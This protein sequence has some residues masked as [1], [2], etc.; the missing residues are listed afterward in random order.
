METGTNNVPIESQIFR[1]DNLSLAI[2]LSA[3]GCKF[4]QSDGRTLAGLNQY[5]LGFIRG[6][7]DP[8]TGEPRAKGLTHEDAIRLI[9]KQGIPGN[10]IYFFERCEVLTAFCLGWDEQ[11]QTGVGDEVP[12]ATEAKDAGRIARRLAQTR[13][14]FIGDKYTTALWRRRDEDGNLFIPAIAHNVGTTSTEP[15][16]DKSTR[17]TIRGASLRAVK[18]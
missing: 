8:K 7:L 4:A 17:T 15:T 1:C 5:T 12:I 3:M 9:W 11:G 14:E 16:G 6:Q 13:A 10:V 18:I 2:A